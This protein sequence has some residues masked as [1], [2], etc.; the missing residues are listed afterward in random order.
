MM[1]QLRNFVM[2]LSINYIVISI[3]LVLAGWDIKDRQLF[4]T[5][6]AALV[7]TALTVTVRRF[8]LALTLPLIIMSMGLF[9][10]IVDGVI[11]AL[12]AAFT[13][14]RVDSAWWVLW[15]V[16]V[17]SF[18]NI[19]AER[20]FRALGW[21]RDAN[22][23][24]ERENNVLTARSTTWGRRVLLFLILMGGIVFSGAMA[25]QIF[26]A[27]G[28]VTRDMTAMLIVAGVAFAL[29]VYGIAWLVAEGLA[30]ERRVLFASLIMIPTTALAIAPAAYYLLADTPGVVVSAPTP[31]PETAY[32]DLSTGSRIAYSAFLVQQVAERNPIVYL[33]GG[34]GRAVLDEDIA[35]FREFANFGIDVYL[36]D[37]VGTGLSARLE[38]VRD[39]TL[40]RH[41]LDLE[42]IRGTIEADRLIL[43][44]HAEGAEVAIRY[45]IAHRDRVERVVF[46]SPTSM[47]NDE[48]HYR[49]NA[50]TAVDVIPADTLPSLRQIVALAL[51]VY[52][53]Q[54]AAA[55]M[56]QQEMTTW[57]DL[58]TDEGMMV[59]TRHSALA[60]NPV[61]PGYNPYVG[62]V[63]DTTD[64]LPPDPRQ[65][66]REIFIPTILLRGECDYVNWSVAQQYWDA[67]PNIHIY[68]VPGA[69][70]ML[71][72]TQ[73][74]LVRELILAFINETPMPQAPLSDWVIRNALPMLEDWQQT[75]VDDLGLEP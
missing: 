20:A 60:P 68:Y 71:Y 29:F 45:M 6:F 64:D 13:G 23:N 69:G 55:N 70:S 49:N 73:P 56:S 14:L 37:L 19:W 61:S 34:L 74:E 65:E 28:L 21:L 42:A 43:V 8:L 72:L 58:T 41:V 16:L 35:F 7:F 47:W 11:L 50:R 51:G 18:V 3:L 17:M 36:Y 66:L 1:R 67:V 40:D 9:I 54:T 4:G 63:G 24:D 48:D 38:D 27:M 53:P 57:A 22:G 59:C 15:G 31:R 5:W 12:T 39:Y 75:L 44:A 2:R 46:L 10:F 26:I 62:L 32:W 30:L 33:H 25:G 52:S